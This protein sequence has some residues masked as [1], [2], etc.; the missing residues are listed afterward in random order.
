MILNKTTAKIKLISE[1]EFNYILCEDGRCDNLSVRYPIIRG[2]IS[3]NHG[4]FVIEVKIP[5]KLYF[6]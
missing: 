6:F 2:I 5:E 3:A 4:R 1:L